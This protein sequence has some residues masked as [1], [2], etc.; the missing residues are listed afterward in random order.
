M[1]ISFLMYPGD[2][3]DADGVKLFEVLA[4]LESPFHI[5]VAPKFPHPRRLDVNSPKPL[6]VL[7]DSVMLKTGEPLMMDADYS[8]MPTRIYNYANPYC[9]ISIRC[10]RHIKLTHHIH[11]QN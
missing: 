9:R 8:I 7:G 11:N 10:A 3:V 1:A 6:P 5:T 2:S 4:V